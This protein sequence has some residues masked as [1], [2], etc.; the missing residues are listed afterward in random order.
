VP[1][2]D[3]LDIKLID[4]TFQ[5]PRK[6]IQDG[7]CKANLSCPQGSLCSII[8][9]PGQGRKTL[10]ELIGHKLFPTEGMIFIP[11]HL[12]ILYVSDEPTILNLSV[13]QNLTF[14]NHKFNNPD[15]VE[16]ILKA[17]DM[18]EVME[19]C[20]PDLE[21][22]RRELTVDTTEARVDDQDHEDTEEQEDQPRRGAN[23]LD[24][25][26][27]SQKSEIHLARAFI[28][29]PE[30]MV[31]HRP[32]KAYPVNVNVP[33][34]RTTFLEALKEHKS[35]RGYK[36]AQESVKDRR[37]RTIF[38]TPDTEKEEEYADLIWR[39]PDGPGNIEALKGKAAMDAL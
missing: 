15:R 7:F 14:G 10:L 31:M 18:D 37:P 24:K 13:W 9:K 22:R 8:G 28:M 11:S 36:M 38:F 19:L 6:P 34:K 21:A 5:H 20:R 3:Q 33:V 25:L 23:D 30:V 16:S 12:R 26:R 35:N 17:L 39:L 4:M 1:A 27:S 32:F 2:A 29:N